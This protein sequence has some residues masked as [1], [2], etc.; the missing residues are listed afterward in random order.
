LVSGLVALEVDA[1]QLGDASWQPEQAAQLAYLHAP[2]SRYGDHGD[3][4]T[5]GGQQRVD[6]RRGP[7][8]E[9]VASRAYERAVDVDVEDVGA[10]QAW[11]GRRAPE[12]GPPAGAREPRRSPARAT[13]ASARG[14]SRAAP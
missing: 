3:P 1:S 2:A 5:A 11:R 7:F 10:R 12:A 9:E 6:Q 14:A 13:G 4:G 8:P